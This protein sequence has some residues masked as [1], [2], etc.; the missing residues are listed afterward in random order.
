VKSIRIAI[1]LDIVIHFLRLTWRKL[2]D[3]GHPAVYCVLDTPTD[4]IIVLGVVESH[5]VPRNDQPSPSYGGHYRFRTEHQIACMAQSSGR[6]VDTLENAAII[7]PERFSYMYRPTGPCFRHTKA[8][9][10]AVDRIR[11]SLNPIS[12]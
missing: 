9:A 1:Y 6:A 4:P 12:T 5:L 7:F 2:S 10:A 11:N 8:V 3:E